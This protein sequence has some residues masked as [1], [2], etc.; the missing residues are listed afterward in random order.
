MQIEQKSSNDDPLLLKVQFINGLSLVAL[1]ML[2]EDER[3]QN[4][5]E[6]DTEEETVT[7]D[8]EIRNVTKAL[9]PFIL[10][11]IRDLGTPNME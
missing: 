1:A 9:S 2:S 5:Q 4:H 10:P 8:S 7:I 6:S 3:K 11:I